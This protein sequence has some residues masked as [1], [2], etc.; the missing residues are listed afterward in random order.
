[1]ASGTI[2]LLRRKPEFGIRKIYFEINFLKNTFFM[3]LGDNFSICVVKLRIL[4]KRI[5]QWILNSTTQMLKM[6][7]KTRKNIFS[8]SLFQNKICEFRPLVFSYAK[9]WFQRSW[10]NCANRFYRG[11]KI[12][13]RKVT[14]FVNKNF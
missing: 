4:C 6:S 8:K 7:P 10:E 3:V 13:N 11:I 5:L 1:M 9:V 14:F 2:L 12:F